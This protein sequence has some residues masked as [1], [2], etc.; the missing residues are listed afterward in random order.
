[1]LLDVL[2][3]EHDPGL[4]GTDE[5]AQE[6]DRVT[7]DLADRRCRTREHVEQ[8]ILQLPNRVDDGLGEVDRLVDEALVLLLERDDP[9]VELL[10]RGGVLLGEGVDQLVLL[11]VNIRLKRIELGGHL[12][13]GGLADLLEILRQALDVGLDLGATLLDPGLRLLQFAADEVRDLADDASHQAQ[14]DVLALLVELVHRGRQRSEL[15]AKPAAF[16]ADA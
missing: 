4:D 3:E 9:L 8:Q 1:V 15:V 11:G 5:V 12:R 6:A 10:A 14:V 7:D 16:A 2:L 13:L